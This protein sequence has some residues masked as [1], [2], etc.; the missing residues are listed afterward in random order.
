MRIKTFYARTMADALREIKAHL[1]PDALILSTK[2]VAR[3]SGA[4]SGSTGFEVVAAVD[5]ADMFDDFSSSSE[6]KPHSVKRT[7]SEA[8]PILPPV[9]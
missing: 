9:C 6:A 7:E 3:R 4:W 5:D 2:E 1:G 8:E